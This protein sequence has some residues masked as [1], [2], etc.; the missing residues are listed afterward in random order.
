MQGF[1]A[2]NCGG[3]GASFRTEYIKE[4]MK[5]TKVDALGQC[6]HNAD[7]PTVSD[8]YPPFQIVTLGRNTN[9]LYLPIMALL[10]AISYRCSK[11]TSL[12]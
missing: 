6:M 7:L 4:M 11:T 8:W 2:S 10:N 1:L 12:C 5:Y 3:G 9:N